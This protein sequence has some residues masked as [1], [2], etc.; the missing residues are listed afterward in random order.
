MSR[1]TP[2]IDDMPP[3]EAPGVDI[4]A[5]QLLRVWR[6]H[7]RLFFL[8][9]FAVLTMGGLALETLTP[10]YMA[11]AVVAIS[12]RM[13]DPLAPTYEQP[14]DRLADEDLPGTIASMMQSRDVA[15]AVLAEIPPLRIQ[16]WCG[17]DAA[18]RR[19]GLPIFC[20]QRFIDSSLKQQSDINQF[21]QTLTVLPLEN[22]RIIDVS[23]TAS[24]GTR[25]AMLA[26]AV[27][28]NYQRIAVARQTTE[29]NRMATWL[30]TRTDELRQRWL[31]A[32][33]TANTF[34]VSHNLT[35]ATEGNG[36]TPLI[37]RQISDTA[38]SLA[39]AQSL[40]ATAQAQS[41]ALHAGDLLASIQQKLAFAKALT[42]QLTAALNQL[43]AQAS[44]QSA[45]Q[46]EYLSLNAEAVSAHT[47]YET[48]LKQADDIV[49]R[50]ALLE[51]PV[52][53][54]SNASV[55]LHPTFPN[56][57]KMVIGILFLGLVAGVGATL[58]SD[59]F[60]EG[61]EEA[62]DLRS[63]AQL[64]LIASIPFITPKQNQSIANHILDEPYS[65]ASEAIRGVVATLSLL[66]DGRDGARSVLITSAGAIEG[67]ST[68]ALWLAMTA[69]QG[70][71]T[72]LLVDGDHRRGLQTRNSLST[73]SLGLTDL[74]SGKAK[75]TDVIQSDA[76]SGIDIIGGGKAEA[77]SF[78]TQEIDRLR[79]TILTL[80]QSYSLIVIDS[81]PLL[82]LV[83]GFVLA[84]VAN[85][86]LF[87]CRWQQTSRRAVRAS[88][89]RL[90]TCGVQVSGIVVTMVKQ[91]S[92]VTFDGG[93]S[94]REAKLITRLYGS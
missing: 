28:R 84:S 45:A 64:P 88:L 60:S 74:L 17:L 5:K 55:P 46:A 57:P 48:F 34:S 15:A 53:I 11:T 67:K 42:H 25:A 39:A 29:S 66:A 71:Q 40:L 72:V 27:V 14:S 38:T 31:N 49:D 3:S 68:L 51:P 69:R 13:A 18:L 30:E 9:L 62:D 92:A 54:V 85:Q 63:S 59:H 26:N 41:E 21:L 12:D 4:A 75:L 8:C 36:S 7:L 16:R 52:T 22:S 58:I 77:R 33:D 2:V 81:P 10:T 90:R 56:K 43:R 83:D 76:D 1:R 44:A 19:M 32:V 87:V 91:N 6:R 47:D 82:A 61:F 23:V 89:D 37:D 65:R 20:G 70:G 78:G 73:L 35:N 80:K 79:N 94:R 50:A 24:T 86:T 93:Y